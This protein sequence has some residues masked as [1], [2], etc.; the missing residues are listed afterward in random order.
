M[1]QEVSKKGKLAIAKF[2]NTE[3]G[4]ELKGYL[5][6]ITPSVVVSEFAHVMHFTSGT[7]QG[8][9]HCMKELEKLSTM[10]GMEENIESDDSLER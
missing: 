7:I 10:K 4:E 9:A 2:L 5:A 1:N 8:W 3:A 6:Y